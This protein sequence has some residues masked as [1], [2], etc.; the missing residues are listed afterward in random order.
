[1][2][3]M[4]RPAFGQVERHV[5][6]QSFNRALRETTIRCCLPELAFITDLRTLFGHMYPLKTL[7]S[8]CVCGLLILLSIWTIVMD[9]YRNCVMCRRGLHRA[10]YQQH[11]LTDALPGER[12]AFAAY[13]QENAVLEVSTSFI[14]VLHS[15]LFI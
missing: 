8:A 11:V 5:A 9:E 14:Y 4:P 12:P 2:Y 6:H 3:S 13:I 10:R 7:T 15:R 1:M